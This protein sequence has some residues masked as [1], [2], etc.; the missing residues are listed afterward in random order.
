VALHR[1]TDLMDQPTPQTLALL[2]LIADNV[3]RAVRP[4]TLDAELELA[5]SSIRQLY[6]AAACSIALLEDNGSQL[7]FRAANGVGADAIIG[8]SLPLGRGIAGWAAMTGQGI[9]VADVERDPRFAKD[10]AEA[11]SYVPRHIIAVPLIDDAGSV[12]GVLE[13]LDS[14]RSDEHTGRDLDV[15]A[16]LSSQLTAVVRLCQL[17]DSLGDTLVRALAEGAD[18]VTFAVALS[19]LARGGPMVDELALLADSFRELADCGAD[20]RRLAQAVMA[21]VVA[22]VKGRR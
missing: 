8:M 22:F 2:R 16:L 5:V 18:E 9:A 11:T 21:D 13:V 1:H 3:G 12:S 15:L 10:V 20:A 6:E 7:R 14:K 4:A 17:Y 19:E